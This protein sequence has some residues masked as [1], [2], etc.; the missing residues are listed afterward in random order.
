MAI[1]IRM[2]AQ[3]FGMSEYELRNKFCEFGFKVDSKEEK[4]DEGT[5]TKFEEKLKMEMAKQ[6]EVKP[7]RTKTIEIPRI[8]PVK[9]LAERMEL[10]VTTVISELMKNGLMVTINENIDF[11]T[12][13]IISEDLGFKVKEEKIDL[14]K[15]AKAGQKLLIDDL[16]KEENEKELKSRAPVVTIVGHVDHGK[17]TLLD[18]IRETN[19][20][21][22][23]AGGIT[24]YISA[25]PVSYTHL[26]LPTIYSV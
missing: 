24:Q 16:L 23:E 17:T 9:E 20:T 7:K 4:I 26:T 13:A 6:E 19:I 14:L 1:K 22:S 5:V 3:K 2:I 21:A 8:I 10:P 15:A 25:Y 11:E 18:A 12:A